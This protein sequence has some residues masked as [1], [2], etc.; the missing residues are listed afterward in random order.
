V[1]PG[2][3]RAGPTSSASPA[4]AAARPAALGWAARRGS[5][6]PHNQLAHRPHLPRCG[7]L[8]Q[9]RLDRA[10][11]LV[12]EGG[13]R[14]AR[15][16]S[17]NASSPPARTRPSARR[18]LAWLTCSCWA[19]C[20]TGQPWSRSLTHCS[21][22]RRR[23]A[24]VARRSPARSSACW[25]AVSRNGAAGRAIA[26]A[27]PHHQSQ[28]QRRHG[29]DPLFRHPLLSFTYEGD[30]SSRPLP[31]SSPAASVTSTLKTQ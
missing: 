30:T 22:T 9:P 20:G 23:G 26:R 7:G 2:A 19:I 31:A 24:T 14:P 1:R 4:R 27:W 17:A 18:T 5:G 3:R 16:R 8:A 21:R 28:H 25:S 11:I 13:G 15:G 29:H 12:A 6:Q 10:A